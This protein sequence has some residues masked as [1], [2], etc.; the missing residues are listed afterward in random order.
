MDIANFLNKLHSQI[1]GLKCDAD[2]RI[3]AK[4]NHWRVN[5]TPSYSNYV[6][7]GGSDIGYLAHMFARAGVDKE[8][9]IIFII[10]LCGLSG[11][12]D[13]I[14]NGYSDTEY[15]EQFRYIASK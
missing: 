1:A 14:E 3:M 7:G 2:A 6:K 15:E 9:A 8:A 5:G 13:E 4:I 12:M 11:S 10:D